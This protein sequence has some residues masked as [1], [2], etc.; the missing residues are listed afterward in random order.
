M[1]FKVSEEKKIEWKRKAIENQNAARDMIQKI[2][3]S[4][5]TNPE[6]IAEILQFAAG[7][8]KYS[9]NNTELIMSQNRG[10][11]YVQSFEAWKKMDA[12]V[13]KGERGLKIWVP[14][15]STI[16]YPPGEKPV[17]YS[18]ATNEQKLDYESGIIPGKSS[19]HYKIGTVFDVSQTDFPVEK[20]P[21]F[22][23]MGYSSEDH[24]LISAGLIDFCA[25]NGCEVKREDLS[26]VSLRGF[27]DGVKNYIAINELLEDTQFLS[28]LSHEIG[29]MLEKHGT[30]DRDISPAQKEFEADCV[31]VVIQSYFGVE[32]T[33]LRKRHLA[34]NYREFLS[35]VKMKN[36]SISEEEQIKLVENVMDSALSVF[37]SNA[38][39]MIFCV[40]NRLS[41]KNEA[42]ESNPETS[43]EDVQEEAKDRPLSV[44]DI[45]N[46]EYVSAEYSNF[47]HTAEYDLEANIR[48]EH[49]TIHYEVTKHDGDEESFSIHTDENDIYDI[50]SESDLRTLEGRLS[51]EVRIGQ[52]LQK[53]DRAETEEDLDSIRFEFME[54]E[55]FPRRLSSRFYE[56]YDTKEKIINPQ[57]R[58]EVAEEPIAETDEK[59]VETAKSFGPLEVLGSETH[60]RD[61]EEISEIDEYEA[62]YGADGKR[63]FPHLNDDPEEQLAQRLDKFVYENDF[64]NYDGSPEDNIKTILDDL[65]SGNVDSIKKYLDVIISDSDVLSENFKTELKELIAGNKHLIEQT[66]GGFEGVDII[67]FIP[68][69][70]QIVNNYLKGF[71]V[72]DDMSGRTELSEKERTHVSSLSDQIETFLQARQLLSYLNNLGTP[73]NI[74]T[75][76]SEEKSQ[77]E[78]VEITAPVAANRRHRR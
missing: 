69:D 54:D 3:Q 63:A 41:A 6:E 5:T 34:E 7:F 14:V 16:L 71:L 9:I 21:V 35:E 42:H 2:S 15:R 22:Y 44:D 30:Q 19:L 10:A 70:M 27:Y 26:S 76:D 68:D 20:L 38:E 33:D 78:I 66:S 8:Y 29:H 57:S 4:Y 25:E 45:Q 73:K 49:Q 32:L 61:T 46:I 77:K 13:K 1:A 36:P 40:N 48:G 51:D 23:S 67:R 53:I 11:T 74:L 50:L 65:R 24:A 28:T 64:Y 75:D 39:K 12:H 43:S 72:S 58:Q 62:E 59:T 18:D 47:G 31:S 37:R 17:P 52:Y 56:V 55:S 60:F